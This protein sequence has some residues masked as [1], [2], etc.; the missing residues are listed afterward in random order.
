M[1]KYIRIIDNAYNNYYD[2]IKIYI[3]NILL[4]ME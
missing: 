2:L 4:Y 3:Y 1:V